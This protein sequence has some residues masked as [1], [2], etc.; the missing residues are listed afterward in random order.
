MFAANHPKGTRGQFPEGYCWG[1]II[2]GIIFLEQSSRGQ[3]S[4]GAIVREAIIR[5]AIIQGAI[6]RGELSGGDNFPRGKFSGHQ[7]KH[8]KA[9]TIVIT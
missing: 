7:L 6:V 1:A 8:I 3:F 2:L 5:G 9:K 4:S